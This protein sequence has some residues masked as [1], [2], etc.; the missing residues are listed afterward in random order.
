MNLRLFV[1]FIYLILLFSNQAWSLTIVSPEEG[2]VVNQGDKVT[3]IVKP[4]SGEN[5]TEVYLSITPMTYSGLTNDYRETM[6]ISS[7]TMGNFDFN[8]Y[9]YN[10]DSGKSIKVTRN[11]LVKMPQDA[12]L[13]SIMVSNEIMVVRKVPPDIIVDDIQ[14]IE[15]RPLSV[16]GVYSD[17]VTR[18]ITSSAMGTTYS[19]SD[20][21]IVTVDSE[22]RVRAQ[23][24]GEAKITVH[25][26]N[27]IAEV[28]V[29][30]QPYK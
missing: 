9:A 25:N 8:V 30:V 20:E 6:T 1:L 23:G 4:D 13:L 17:G 10:D 16:A 3:V 21:K 26:G 22:G 14:Q 7:N 24:I 19:S 28:E 11:I 29:I 2:Q 27:Y 18:L 5:W 12:V 15:T